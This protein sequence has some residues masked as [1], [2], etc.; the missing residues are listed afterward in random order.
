MTTTALIVCG[1]LVCEDLALKQEHAWQV[2]ILGVPRLLHE[3]PERIPAAVWQRI[4][5]AKGEYQSAPRNPVYRIWFA[6]ETHV[7]FVERMSI[8]SQLSFN[9]LQD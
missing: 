1:V 9:L 3:E 2:D 6:G 7:G 4:R 5:G 8:S